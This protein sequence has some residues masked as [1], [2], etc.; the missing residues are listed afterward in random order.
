M[1][2]RRNPYKPLEAALGY[3]FRKRR[4]LE[5]AL[6]HPSYAHEQAGGA[7]AHNQRLEFLGDA[8]LG[9]VAASA[10]YEMY[11]ESPEGDLTKL[12]SAISS[13]RALAEVARQIGLG[14]YLRLGRGEETA[15]GRARPS[16]LADAMEA[17]I[18]AAFLDGGLKAVE[19]IFMACFAAR[20]TPALAV[21]WME[22]PKGALQELAHKKGKGIPAY[23]MVREE[24]P[25]HARIFTAHVLVGGALLGEGRGRTKREAEQDAARRAIQR[26]IAPDASP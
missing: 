19:K 25:A 14:H 24:G 12:R 20:L 10:L 4:F 17:V 1:I 13:T 16:I 3:R 21:S 6:T 23:Q 2:L 15:G 11:P 22:N 9:L 5:Q 7:I 8:A 26:L 18:G